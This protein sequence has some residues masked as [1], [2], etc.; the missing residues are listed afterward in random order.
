M[1]N[2]SF[3]ILIPLAV[4]FVTSACEIRDVTVDPNWENGKRDTQKSDIPGTLDGRITDATNRYRDS[5]GNDGRTQIDG[6]E[7]ADGSYTWGE[8]GAIDT[9]LTRIDADLIGDGGSEAGL[10]GDGSNNKDGQDGAKD[11]A[12][13]DST[14]TQEDGGNV[15]P[16]E[17]YFDDFESGDDNWILS[18]YDWDITDALSRSESHSLTDSPE[19]SFLSYSDTAA[20]LAKSLDISN[21]MKPTLSFWYQGNVSDY[22]DRAIV[23]VSSDGG[24]NWTTIWDSRQWVLS[25]WSFVSLDLTAYKSTTFKLRFRLT[26]NDNTESDGWYVDDVS[27]DEADTEGDSFP[28]FDDFESGDDNWILSGCDWDIT[29]DFSR[30]ESHS[31]TDSSE[32]SFLSYSDAAATLAKSL[33]ISNATKPTLSFWYQG[34]VSDYYDRAIVDV[35]SLEFGDFLSKKKVWIAL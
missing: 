33:D 23:D 5:I 16:M 13:K 24:I 27:I 31:L 8:S 4:F 9:G 32:T 14:A 22:Y 2:I 17:T 34:D 12:A 15:G 20:T 18:G 19:A 10:I 29:D 11:G 30:S 26:S 1:R 3:Y 21:G 25:T 6:P 35:S 7:N 28:F